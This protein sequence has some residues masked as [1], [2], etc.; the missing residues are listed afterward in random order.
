LRGGTRRVV[1]SRTATP[2]HAMT[3]LRSLAAMAALALIAS[4]TGCASEPSAATAPE[5]VDGGVR[6][7]ATGLDGWQ[8]HRVLRF[9]D[10]ATSPVDPKMA[11]LS[12]AGCLPDCPRQTTVTSSGAHAPIYR[13]QFDDA[14]KSESIKVAFEQHGPSAQVAQVRAIYEA[15]RYSTLQMTEWM[16][17]PTSLKGNAEFVTRFTGVIEP[18]APGQLA[19]HFALFSDDATDDA[20]TPAGW[21]VDDNGRRLAIR[22]APFPAGTPAIVVRMA[23]GISPGYRFE[24]DGQVVGSVDVFP[25]KA[26]WLRDDLAPDLRFALAGL[27]SALLLRPH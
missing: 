12:A 26:V 24:L 27:S 9:G 15:Q 19:W 10:Y 16:G 17:F 20:A 4:F 23:H 7:P 8:F 14:F 2:I 5:H 1:Q 21:I 25:G 13:K 22:H 6:L 18:A 3:P 11:S